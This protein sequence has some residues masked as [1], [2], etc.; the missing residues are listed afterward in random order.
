MKRTFI[1]VGALMLAL[2]S[3]NGGTSTSDGTHKE[4]KI[5][6]IDF[7]EFR[8]TDISPKAQEDIRQWKQFQSL[9][10]V[11]VSMAPAKIKNSGDLMVSNPDSLL[12]YSRLYPLN[13]KTTIVNGL[14]EQDWR[15][16][17]NG[18]K[19][20]IFRLE[21]KKEHQMAY[22]EWQQFL[23]AHIPYTFSIVMKKVNYD[24]ILL[25]FNE[26]E[27]EELK[28]VLSLDT[29]SPPSN[30]VIQKALGDEWQE[31]KIVFSPKKTTSYSIRLALNEEAK[32]NDNVILYRSVLEL[33]A[34]YFEKIGQYSEK[35]ASQKA[36]VES[37]Y[38]SVFFW[39]IQIEESLKEL[40]NNDSFPKRID[41]PTV[42]ARFRLF[43]TQIRALADNVKNNPD[44]KEEELKYNIY[45]LGQTFNSII[46]RIN[47][48]YNNDLD[49][50][51]RSI[52][53]AQ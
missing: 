32:E 45:L 16:P 46:A 3:C 14:V 39:L 17:P 19:D 28:T 9:M 27:Q 26:G 13:S 18:A 4:H 30:G 43:E 22:L 44:F 40:L 49:D 25:Y 10:Q 8:L 53:T 48:I 51:M 36:E 24:K 11:I 12:I 50:R 31:Y 6:S 1:A 23:V 52:D 29:L 42:K 37:S 34:K 21:K 15:T 38:Y 2:S 7:E 41:V 20:T 33:P 5:K 47:N 35:I